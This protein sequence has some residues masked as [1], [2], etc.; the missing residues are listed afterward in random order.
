[1][2]I[3]IGKKQILLILLILALGFGVGYLAGYAF[4]HWL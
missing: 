4:S 1:M 2:R 3:V